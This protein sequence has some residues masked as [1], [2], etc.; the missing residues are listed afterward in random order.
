MSVNS[1]RRCSAI[2]KG[3]ALQWRQVLA[4]PIKYSINAASKQKCVRYKKGSI[5]SSHMTESCLEG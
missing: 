1:E 3:G 4:H 2:V 5:I